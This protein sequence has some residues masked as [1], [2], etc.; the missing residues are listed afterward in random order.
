[1]FEVVFNQ[2]IFRVFFISAVPPDSRHLSF[3]NRYPCFLLRYP[4][5]TKNVPFFSNL[6]LCPSTFIDK[7]AQTEMDLFFFCCYN[8]LNIQTIKSIFFSVVLFISIQ[9]LSHKTVEC[10]QFSLGCSHAIGVSLY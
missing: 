2:D 10:Y 1:M 4:Y 6:R 9:N 5:Y 3:L 7:I 8:F